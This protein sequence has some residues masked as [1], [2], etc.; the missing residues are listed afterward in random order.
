MSSTR[1]VPYPAHL[2]IRP[3]LR[4]RFQFVWAQRDFPYVVLILAGFLW[5]VAFR[6]PDRL[7]LAAGIILAGLVLFAVRGGLIIA[8]TVVE[9]DHGEVRWR[10]VFGHGQFR[11]GEV[12]CIQ[13]KRPRLRTAR[14]YPIVTI[15]DRD[16]KILLRF[17]SAWFPPEPAADFEEALTEAVQRAGRTIQQWSMTQTTFGS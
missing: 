3:S 6:W 7:P 14:N 13:T 5:K 1:T 12:S 17:D 4:A 8:R 16:G 10:K 11:V 2:V 9:L 15:R